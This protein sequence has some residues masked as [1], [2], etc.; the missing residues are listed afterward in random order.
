MSRIYRPERTHGVGSHLTGRALEVLAQ[1]V[2]DEG[3]ALLQQTKKTG[4]YL[5]CAMR[6]RVEGP[7]T[8]VQTE[9]L[10]LKVGVSYEFAGEAGQA[11]RLY[12]YLAY[13]TAKDGASD[14]SPKAESLAWKR[15]KPVLP[16]CNKTSRTI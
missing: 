11:I 10:P 15:E 4:F 9:R 5:A 12:K 14:L 7:L 1:N 13:V 8:Q 6:N 2:N 3:G 16:A